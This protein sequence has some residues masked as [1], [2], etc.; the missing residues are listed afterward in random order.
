MKKIL[1]LCAAALLV[2]PGALAGNGKDNTG[3]GLGTMLFG[4]QA[5]D[6]I[7]LQSFAVT[8]NGT[9]GS[10]TFGITSGTSE[11]ERPS[12]FVRNRR[13]NEFVQANL[14]NLAGDIARG[15][16]ETVSAL[17]DLLEVPADRRPDFFRRLQA[18]FRQ[19]FPTPDV[20]YAHVVDSI[21]R[22]QA[23]G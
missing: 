1:I 9:S 18:N 6:S 16:G 7:L 21:A 13:V 10:Q 3:C 14:D 11:C 20:G 5:D 4:D 15:G 8:T 12:S 17:A 19:I 2:A 23:Q 22:L